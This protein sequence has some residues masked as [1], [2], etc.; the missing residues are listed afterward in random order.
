MATDMFYITQEIM[1]CGV[2]QHNIVSDIKMN[3]DSVEFIFILT[4]TVHINQCFTKSAGFSQLANNIL[5]ATRNKQTDRVTLDKQHVA[6]R[7]TE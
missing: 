3:K 5:Q 2:L 6:R 7:Q 4:A 1:G